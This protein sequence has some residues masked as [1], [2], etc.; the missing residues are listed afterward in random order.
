MR[1][2]IEAGAKASAI[3]PRHIYRLAER[4]EFDLLKKLKGAGAD[5]SGALNLA[6]QDGK[7]RQ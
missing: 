4:K 5:V 6:T 2:L 1:I 7:V 3:D